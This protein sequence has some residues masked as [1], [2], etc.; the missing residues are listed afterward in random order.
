MPHTSGRTV[1]DRSP[2]APKGLQ[3]GSRAHEQEIRSVSACTRLSRFSNSAAGLFSV[4]RRGVACAAVCSPFPATR[5]PVK[6]AHR[7]AFYA[8]TD[9]DHLRSKG[10]GSSCHRDQPARLPACAPGQGVFRGPLA[11]C[12]FWRGRCCTTSAHAL[13]EQADASDGNPAISP[14]V[15]ETL[16]QLVPGASDQAGSGRRQFGLASE[17]P[18][19]FAQTRSEKRQRSARHRNFDTHQ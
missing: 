16:A 2:I 14:R 12:Q 1:N 3:R 11:A 15:R 8:A 10:T 7:I 13:S 6:Q 4:G 5:A 18:P 9:P 19:S 17:S